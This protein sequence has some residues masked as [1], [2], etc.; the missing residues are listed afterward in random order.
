MALAVTHST[1]TGAAA[2]TTALVDGPKWDAAHTLTGTSSP[3][4][5]G[6][7]VSNNDASTIT[8]SGSFGLVFSISEAT[9]I[10]LPSTGTLVTLAG[11]EELTDKTLNASVA[12]GVWTVS[13]TWTIPAVTLGGT[14]SGGGNQ[15]NN[16]VIGGTS[17]LAG[18][19]TTLTANT[20][21]AVTGPNTTTVNQNSETQ[22]AVL[23]SSAGTAGAATFYSS[24]GT[25]AIK[26]GMTGTGWSPYGALAANIAYIYGATDFV[27]MSDGGRIIFAS[28]GSSE[29]ARISA[30]GGFSLGTTTDPGAGAYLGT[31]AIRSNGATGGAGYATGAGGTVT[32]ITSK[33]NGATLSKVCGAI[34]TAADAL[35]AGTI[36]SFVLTNTAIAATDVLVLN[37]ISGGT[38]GSYTLNAQCAAGSAT[39]NIRNNTAGS[40]S[41]AIVIQFALIKGVNA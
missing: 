41:E 34:T 7:G 13:G 37:H 20:S 38:V 5:G 40:L 39:I 26:F 10:V 31:G 23:N 27:V 29:K 12:K 32:Q 2:D 4:Q 36:V 33:A 25:A 28:G 35:A 16:V 3:S 8:V 11:T 14:V 24:N 6:T 9:S 19:F 22:V 30:A 21:L 1:V 18:T 15:V 17:P